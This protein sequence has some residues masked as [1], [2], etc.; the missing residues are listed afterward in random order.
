[1]SSAL[2]SP[3]Q[4]Q[5]APNLWP[6]HP[7]DTEDSHQALIGLGI[8]K[9][10]FSSNESSEGDDNIVLPRSVHSPRY[11]SKPATFSPF[12]PEFCP[13]GAASDND[14]AHHHH[15]HLSSP[16]ARLGSDTSLS[17]TSSKG[18]PTPGLVN[19]DSPEAV[20]S[21]LATPEPEDAP[22]PALDASSY[23]KS[24]A[25]RF[26]T[27][28]S[29]PQ[30]ELSDDILKFHISSRDKKDV[31]PFFHQPWSQQQQQSLPSPSRAM[32]PPGPRSS[33]RSQLHPAARPWSPSPLRQEQRPGST[34]TA[35]T[36]T[37]GPREP[38]SPSHSLRPSGL[39]KLHA[40]DESSANRE[41][42]GMQEH[43][44]SRLAM[45][46]LGE[47]EDSPFPLSAFSSWK[48][49][50]T[51]PGGEGEHPAAVETSQSAQTSGLTSRH[52]Q[53]QCSHDSATSSHGSSIEAY[54]LSSPSTHPH[55]HSARPSASRPSSSLLGPSPSDP[56]LSFAQRQQQRQSGRLIVHFKLIQCS[57]CNPIH[58]GAGC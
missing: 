39:S 36:V 28:V 6:P 3:T 17:S 4:D 16:A 2:E 25:F 48:A 9:V 19:F 43:N 18:P 11:E 12:A 46:E 57:L 7:E 44:R 31:Y 38:F 27:P 35:S 1:M 21:P 41:H 34:H 52:H 30:Y 40:V 13:S 24:S 49:Q 22:A 50:R 15:H 23:L 20:N 33:S 55:H 53:R 32:S 47:P 5:G 45:V 29:A 42:F 26:E 10:S 58:S 37:P 56:P 51:E 14:D 54:E 8:R